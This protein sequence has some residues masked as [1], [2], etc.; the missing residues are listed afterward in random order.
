M[1]VREGVRVLLT[2]HQGWLLAGSEAML[3]WLGKHL[4]PLGRH[5][6]TGRQAA[7][8]SS[9]LQTAPGSTL[10]SVLAVGPAATL[11]GRD[12]VTRRRAASPCCVS[13]SA[14][15]HLELDTELD[16]EL[17][18]AGKRLLP[19]FREPQTRA[20]CGALSSKLQRQRGNAT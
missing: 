15:G 3:R 12:S 2:A 9:R 17:D 20:S 10:L 6:L 5:P 1:L 11:S 16:T 13:T 4:V 7:H 19:L 14:S 8:H 18:R